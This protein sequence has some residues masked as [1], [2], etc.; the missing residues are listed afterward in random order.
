MSC[1]REAAQARRAALRRRD[2][3]ERWPREQQT[4]LRPSDELG[5]LK[6]IR[7]GNVGR[8]DGIDSISEKSRVIN[9]VCSAAALEKRL[10]VDLIKVF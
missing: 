10:R 7:E 9:Q 6:K 4:L 1:T 8:E 2:R 5:V 3:D